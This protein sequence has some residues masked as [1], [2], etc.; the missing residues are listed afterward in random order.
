MPPDTAVV[1]TPN[2]VEPLSDDRGTDQICY[3]LGAGFSSDS[4]F[5]L[6]VAD[7]FLDA[8]CSIYCRDAQNCIVQK[9]VSEHRELAALLRRLESRYGRLSGLNLETVMSDLHVRTIGIGRPWEIRDPASIAFVPESGEAATVPLGAAA[10]DPGHD[11]GRDYELLLLYVCLRLR[12]V[13]VTKEQCTR[14]KRLVGKLLHRD[15]VLTLNYDT[16]IE[17]HIIGFMEAVS[18]TEG[19]VGRMHRWIGQPVPAREW[20]PPP[21]FARRVRG[22][23]GVLAKLHGS[24]DWRS[25]ANP[26]CPNYRYIQSID[27]FSKPV[28]DYP[29]IVVCM[30]CG[31][32]MDTVIIPPVSTKS[33]ERFPKLNM[34]WLDAYEALRFARR[35]VFMGVSFA[36][37]DMHLRSLLRAASENLETSDG[38][39]AM[40]PQICVANRDQEGSK[41]AATAL[42][43]CLSPRT[44]QAMAARPAAIS[45]F[46]S[47][48]KYLD[49]AEP[50]D[51]DRK[52]A[53]ES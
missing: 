20:L 24:V 38:R 2:S 26:E 13:E 19:R 51:R 37:T 48:T 10:A 50:V 41:R 28:P 1:L 36:A 40:P 16:L 3:F 23:P 8:S 47:I 39:Q 32:R 33:F 18:L 34:M 35:W 15:S 29:D 25:C 21:M 7:G 30:A 4:A 44:K 52:P 17:R 27:W 9:P 14:T 43:E 53:P 42:M 31:S 6:P 49:C 5:Q 12:L 11:L 22:G 46:D 45:T